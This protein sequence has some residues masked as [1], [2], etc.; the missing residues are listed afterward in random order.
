MLKDLFKK[1]T[2]ATVKS[3]SIKK[4][5]SEE[6]PNIPSGMWVK[7]DKCNAMI[8]GED[9]E[10]S[11]YVCST[12]GYHFRLNAKQRIRMFLDKDT[13][14]EFWRELK[15]TNPLEFEGYE[16]KLKSGKTTSTE[17]VVTGVGQ[18][19]GLSVACAVMDS[20]FMMGSMGTVVGEKITR[21]VE[22]ATEN[23]LPIIIFT[24]SG[25]ARMQEGIYSLMQMAKVSAA[26]ARHD[27]AGLLYITVLTDPTTGGVTA[28]FAMEG[29]IILSEPNALVGFAG[30]RVIENTIKESLPDDFQK[31]EFLLEKGFIDAIV[32]RKN[33]RACIYKI[34]V[35]H[36][37]RNNG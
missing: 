7:C 6:K 27:E 22:Y 13:F 19:N 25:G 14:K 37:V 8:Y 10:N 5:I 26:L 21:L 36:G 17:A 11:K 12:C 30:R 1:K 24:T 29:D 35:L 4:N 23:K 20:F 28:S 33:M 3:S 2:Y 34:L 18:L 9:L 31:A 15:T 16:E 32:E